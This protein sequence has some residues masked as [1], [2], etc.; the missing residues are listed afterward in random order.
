MTDRSW[1][2]RATHLRLG[3][4]GRSTG[5]ADGNG[6]LGYFVGVAGFKLT[7]GLIGQ[8]QGIQYFLLPDHHSRLPFLDTAVPVQMAKRRCELGNR[9]A[10]HEVSTLD[11]PYSSAERSAAR[12][13]VRQA[14]GSDPRSGSPMIASA[15][16]AARN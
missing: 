4:R 14:D 3:E 1:V 16:E 10:N 6:K 15:H 5:Q 9:R 2:S 12:Y 13:T 11:S 8:R 7:D